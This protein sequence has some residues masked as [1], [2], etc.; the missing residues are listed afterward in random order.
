MPSDCSNA[1]L[2]GAIWRMAERSILRLCP[3]AAA[4]TLS[5]I[6]TVQGDSGAGLGTNSTRAESTLGRGVKASA[7]TVKRMRGDARHWEST[8]SRP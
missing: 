4:V 1:S 5:S 6:A 8:A 2:S 7:G 3:K